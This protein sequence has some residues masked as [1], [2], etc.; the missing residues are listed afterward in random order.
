[1]EIE[2][3]QQREVLSLSPGER[4]GVRASI[5]ANSNENVEEPICTTKQYACCSGWLRNIP[6][7]E[8]AASLSVG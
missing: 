5:N 2:W 7:I 4:A 8:A 6:G 1:M 3:F